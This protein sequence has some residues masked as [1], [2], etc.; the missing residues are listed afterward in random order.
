M[1]VL[2]DNDIKNN[3]KVMYLLTHYLSSEECTLIDINLPIFHK[4]L[5]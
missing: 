2:H 4:E 1:R 5:S 3:T